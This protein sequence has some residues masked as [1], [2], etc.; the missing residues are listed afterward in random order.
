MTW[1]ATLEL[2]YTR[3]DVKTL[4]HFRHKGPLDMAGQRCIATLFFV[5]GSKRE[6]QR[7]QGALDVTASKPLL[8][9]LASFVALAPASAQQL[10]INKPPLDVGPDQLDANLV[11]HPQ[12]VMS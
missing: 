9:V 11:A 10:E 6:R 7:R 2:D 5:A 3:Q 1:N 4:A 8:G 12:L